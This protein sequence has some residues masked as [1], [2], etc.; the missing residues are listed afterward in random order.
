M[1]K[2]NTDHAV[3]F[4]LGQ[5]TYKNRSYKNQQWFWDPITYLKKVILAL[6]LIGE[7]LEYI[8]PLKYIILTITLIKQPGSKSKKTIAMI[9]CLTNFTDLLIL[10]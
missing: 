2:T 4:T 6:G 5:K 10:I 9:I 1:H 7:I 3:F 8:S